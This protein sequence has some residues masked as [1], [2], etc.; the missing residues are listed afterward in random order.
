MSEIRLSE[1]IA[2]VF[3]GV[4]RAVRDGAYTHFWLTGGRG[5][6]K[7]SFCAIEIIHGMMQSPDAHALVLRQVKDTLRHSVFE[8]LV[9]AV[10]VL[11]V[12]RDWETTLSP[13]QLKYAPTGQRILLRGADNPA[14]LKSIKLSGG[15]LRYI[16]FEELDEMGGMEDVRRILQSAMRGDG[17]FRVFYTFNPP[18]S[19]R[20]WVNVESMAERPDRLAHN[21]TYLDLP[22]DW[23]GRYFIA[24]AEHLRT[25]SPDRYANE[26]LGRVTGTGGEVFRNIL[27]REVPDCE[28]AEFDR[29]LCGLDFG[30]A[31]DPSAFVLCHFDKA[32]RRLVIFGER[33]ARGLS[34]RALAESI[35][36]LASGGPVFC[37]SADPRSINE[38]RE[39]DIDA[40]AA[41]KG[42]GSV[43][44]GIKTL[45]SLEEIVIDPARCPNTAR[46]FTAYATDPGCDRYPD[47]DNHSI[48]AVRYALECET[49]GCGGR[50]VRLDMR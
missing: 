34:N 49:R 19:K 29:V 30:Y 35:R 44:F 45:A 25:V 24:E 36:E 39:L 1:V 32:R 37:D 4:H 31:A 13:L 22:P 6:G 9:W 48:D 40:R 15:Y 41:R 47:R 46:E 50:F 5:S 3:H 21:S 8:Q 28:I 33:Y 20:A 17:R 16:W 11:G 14:K 23:L 10:H 43:E 27:V 7:S 26:Y 12:Q 18:A 38:L 42:P 2:P